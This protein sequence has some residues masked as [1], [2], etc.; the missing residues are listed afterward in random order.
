MLNLV[1]FTRQCFNHAPDLQDRQRAQKQPGQKELPELFAEEDTEARAVGVDI[2]GGKGEHIQKKGLDKAVQL[3]VG[4]LRVVG[5][6]GQH[7]EKT[8]SVDPVNAFFV[9]KRRSLLQ[10][11]PH[12]NGFISRLQSRDSWDSAFFMLYLFFLLHTIRS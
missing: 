10:D 5:H 11:C 8:R 12:Y 7:A 6:H 1:L 2:A 9:H 3:G 4:E